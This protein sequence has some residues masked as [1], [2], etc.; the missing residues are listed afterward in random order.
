[1]KALRINTEAFSWKVFRVLRTWLF[2]GTG[3]SFFRA[4]SLLVAFR[5]LKLSVTVFNPWIFFTGELW[6]MGVDRTEFSIFVFYLAV[7]IIA[8]ILR[9]VTGKSIRELLKEQNIVFRWIIY[10]GLIYSVL[11]YGCYGSGFSSAAFI[12]QGF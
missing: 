2:F 10:A 9:A 4:G 5:N 7:V 3:L 6:E 1:N 12:Y 8:G 11:I